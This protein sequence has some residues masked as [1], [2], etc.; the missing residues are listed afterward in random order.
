MPAA[1]IRRSSVD[2][3]LQRVDA[4]EYAAEFVA[5][6]REPV[7]NARRNFRIR[8]LFQNAEANQFAQALVEDLFR[9]TLDRAFQR[10][11][12]VTFSKMVGT[13]LAAAQLLEKEGISVEVINLR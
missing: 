11:W 3:A 5:E 8:L 1:L 13:S 10:A 7:F 4:V 2:F 6:D 12:A 9:H